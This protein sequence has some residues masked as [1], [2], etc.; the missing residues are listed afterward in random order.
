MSR[1]RHLSREAGGGVTNGVTTESK[2][3]YIRY[4]RPPS[5]TGGL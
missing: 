5:P 3:A 4:T 2:H 1:K